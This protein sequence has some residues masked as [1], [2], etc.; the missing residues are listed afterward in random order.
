MFVIMCVGI[1]NIF[2]LCVLYVYIHVY[3]RAKVLTCLEQPHELGRL[4]EG[5]RGQQLHLDHLGVNK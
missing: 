1:V 4:A 2:I 3:V 5:H